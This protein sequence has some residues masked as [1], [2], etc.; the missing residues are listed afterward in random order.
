MQTLQVINVRGERRIG[1]LD[2][3]AAS[4]VPMLKKTWELHLRKP[5]QNIRMLTSLCT[6]AH[7]LYTLLHNKTLLLFLPPYPGPDPQSRNNYHNEQPYSLALCRI[8]K[9]FHPAQSNQRLSHPYTN[10]C[11][12]GELSP[13]LTKH[14][15]TNR[16]SRF[17]L[18]SL[19]LGL[20]ISTILLVLVFSVNFALL[21]IGINRFP[22]HTRSST[23]PSCT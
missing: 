19:L 14:S 1:R 5:K 2:K 18:W 4:I 3:E 11:H 8:L 9:Y 6:V 21:S 23:R 10:S 13:R 12:V 7:N 17:T 15:S 20:L 16:S 22:S